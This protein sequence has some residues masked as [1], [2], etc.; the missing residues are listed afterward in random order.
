MSNQQNNRDALIAHIQAQDTII[1]TRNNEITQLNIKLN[2]LMTNE[3]SIPELLEKKVA[4]AY[5]KGWNQAHKA[6]L[7]KLKDDHRIQW[8]AL[9]VLSEPP[10]KVEEK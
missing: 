2:E 9:S 6:I 10:S 5:R 4:N 7:T 1:R 3:P 8:Q